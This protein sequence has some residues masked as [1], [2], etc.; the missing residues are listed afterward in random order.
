MKALVRKIIPFSTVDGPGSRTAVFFQGCNLNCGY[1]HNPETIDMNNSDGVRELCVEE[2]LEEIRPYRNFIRG[3]TFSGGE[4]T[5]HKEF[6]K[7]VFP[8]LK[9][10]GLEIFIDTN[11]LIDLSL[12]QEF[13]DGF[14]R[15]MVD[16]KAADERDH[17]DLTGRSNKMVVKN[18]DY[19]ASLGKLHEIRT[20]VVPEALNNEETVRV[21]ARLLRDR[22]P[23]II[24]KLIRFRPI[25][26]REPY[27]KNKIASM[28]YMEKL[29]DICIEEGLENIVIV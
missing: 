6:L 2:L 9:E 18:I 27:N 25:G 19:L 26:V 12:D 22:D 5:L 24:Y 17:I 11:A 15:A 8:Y 21:G 7:E 29:R 1:C 3:V 14:D 13:L 4:C 10:M 28:E 23:A 16:F 20:V